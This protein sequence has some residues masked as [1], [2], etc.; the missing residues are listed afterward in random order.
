VLAD[1]AGHGGSSRLV[2][3]V[4]TVV[5]SGNDTADDSPVPVPRTGLYRAFGEGR[6]RPSRTQP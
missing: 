2:E 3:E 4:L 1:R 6:E 5:I